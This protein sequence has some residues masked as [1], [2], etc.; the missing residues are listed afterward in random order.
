MGAKAV[1]LLELGLFCKAA[2]TVL[3]TSVTR[4]DNFI[5]KMA[6]TLKGWKK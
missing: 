5:S 3:V 1:Y 2:G 4:L 6:S